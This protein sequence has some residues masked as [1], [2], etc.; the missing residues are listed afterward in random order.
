[1]LSTNPGAEEIFLLYPNKWYYNQ[2]SENPFLPIIK[3]LVQRTTLLKEELIALHPD[4]I[5]KYVQA[6]YSLTD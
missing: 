5:I 4:R 2:L 3:S 1:M 6:G